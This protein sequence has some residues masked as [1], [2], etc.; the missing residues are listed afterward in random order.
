MKRAFGTTATA[1]KSDAWP[2]IG[3]ACSYLWNNESHTSILLLIGTYTFDANKFRSNYFMM[4]VTCFSEESEPPLESNPTFAGQ[5]TP[6]GNILSR[7]SN[8]ALYK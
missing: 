7:E 8:C 3:K 1:V 4:N 2:G 5:T 6:K